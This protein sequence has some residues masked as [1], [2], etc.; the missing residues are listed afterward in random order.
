MFVNVFYLFIA[1][2]QL[3]CFFCL[4]MIKWIYFRFVFSWLISWMLSLHCVHFVVLMK[5]IWLD[6]RVICFLIDDIALASVY[7]H[8]IWL[9]C[10]W[11]WS[12][13]E[14][15]VAFI[16][17]CCKSSVRFCVICVY[18]ALFVLQWQCSVPFY[19]FVI[20]F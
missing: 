3:V 16:L 10:P 2:F 20:S 8:R 5:L 6:D 12:Y 18:I 13:V 7:Y 19:L 14:M 1:F 15:S 11:K 17:S 9:Y 4:P